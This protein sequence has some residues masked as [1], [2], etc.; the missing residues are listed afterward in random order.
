VKEL[1]TAKYTLSTKILPRILLTQK[2]TDKM[3]E[4]KIA[5]KIKS[6]AR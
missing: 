2:K 6:K 3:K 4:K 1:Q 5:Q